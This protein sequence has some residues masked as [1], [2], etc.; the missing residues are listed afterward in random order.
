MAREPVRRIQGVS[1]IQPVAQPTD[2]YVRP[3]EPSPSPLREVAQGLSE[4]DS[5]MGAFLAKRKQKQ[6]DADKVRAEAAFNSNNALGWAEAVKQG[7]VPAHASPVFMKA[8]KA[9]QGNLAGIQLREKFNGAYLNWDGRNSNDPQAFQTFLGDFI[10]SNVQ[11][12]DPDMLAPLNEHVRQLW[13]DGHQMFTSESAKS[14]YNGNLNT[15]A[16]ISGRSIDAANDEGLGNGKGTDY[17]R[18]WGDLIAQR[19]E[20]LSAGTR[21]EDYD[22]TLV[23]T[24]A[25]KA[26]EHGDPAMLDLLDKMLPGDTVKMSDYPD[27]RDVK[28]DTISKIDTL[29]RQRM[30][31]EDA[32]RKKKDTERERT[33]EATVSRV[34]AEDP[35]AEVPED[36]MREW[37][38]YDGLARKKLVEI[39][40]TLADADST[41]ERGRINDLL[42]DIRNGQGPARVLK[43]AQDGVIRNPATL[44]D[45]LDRADRYEKARREGTGILT[46]QTTKRYLGVIR[47]RTTSMDDSANL[48]SSL[49]SGGTGG[50]TDEGLEATQDFEAML[51]EW[52]EK[53]PEASMMDREKAINE[54]GQLIIQRIDP[55]ITDV[56]NPDKYRSRAQIE[57]DE[58]TAILHPEGAPTPVPSNSLPSG[59]AGRWEQLYSGDQPPF[60]ERLD[61]VELKRLKDNLPEGVPIEQFNADVWN[62]VREILKEER[63]DNPPGVDPMKTDS[64]TF[65][66]E[67]AKQTADAIGQMID[68]VV[69]NGG[70]STNLSDSPTLPI[71][72]LIGHTEGTDEGRGY[73]ETLGYGAYTGG[74][75]DLTK[76]TLGDIKK[77]QSQM[78]AHPDNKWNSSALGRYQ[79]VGKTL[80]TLQQQMKLSDSVLFDEKTQDAM[81]MQLLK[82]R[83]YDDWMA[84]KISDATFMN[85][86]AKEW[87]S[88]PTTAG[89][90]YYDGQKARVGTDSVLTAFAAMK[91]P[92]ESP[93]D[94]ILTPQATKPNPAVYK[95]IPEKEV[96]QFLE[97]NPDPVANHE[98]NLKTLKP[99][100]GDVVKRAQELSGVK[101]VIGAGARTEE[102][103]KK[104]VK[105][106][107]SKT[108]DSDHLDKDGSGSR[109]VDLWPVDDDGAVDFD[110]AKQMAIVSAMK[111]AAK[112]LGVT[113]DI[114]AEWKKTKDKPHFAIK[115]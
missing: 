35:M 95:K 73:N 44:K 50:L 106:G 41:E 88:L 3:A 12:D 38:R 90:G 86:L 112:E 55:A 94:A 5:G 14:V 43:A 4:L 11:T 19:E 36:V 32:L 83:G 54:I 69:G 49:L 78:L 58:G 92:K 72:N 59:N 28:H 40:K 111:Q 101:F 1:A 113:L 31:D 47:D 42:I 52:E 57:R 108:M 93:F 62:E 7:K 45:M 21:R 71:L 46:A 74:D 80:R 67:T 66:N 15:R 61:D 103:Q 65:D 13:A 109:A 100:L 68:N 6:D 2:T 79:I 30:V 76:M 48:L 29:N 70:Y 25:A 18:L 53:N 81:A 63:G 23:S 33:I 39:R 102:L 114:G 97:W 20:A 22:K 26:L 89:K 60:L 115:A 64:I 107:W 17:E 51:M 9:A 91:A 8:Y 99:K 10:K 96:A 16:A 98:A 24:I 84:G 82:G 37:E 85:N 56:K 75:K 104:A 77:L 34:L 27:Y 105:W 87:A 110:D